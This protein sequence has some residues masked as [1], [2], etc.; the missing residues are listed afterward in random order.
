MEPGDYFDPIFELPLWLVWLLLV[1]ACVLALEAGRWA[2]RRAAAH[3]R[4]GTRE[5]KS[6][7]EGYVFGAIFSL[8]AFMIAIT[9]SIALGR[10]DSRRL[11]VN[12]YIFVAL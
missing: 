8:L 11:L 7:A 5:A 9:F 3:R 10:F 4:A 12:H 6:E 2:F 1:A